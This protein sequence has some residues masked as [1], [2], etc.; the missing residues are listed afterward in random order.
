[1]AHISTSIDIIDLTAE[2]DEF[3]RAEYMRGSSTRV[4]AAA[5]LLTSQFRAQERSSQPSRFRVKDVDIVDLSERTPSPKISSK[6]FKSPGEPSSQRSTDGTVP[7]SLQRNSLLASPTRPA[8][9]SGLGESL[10]SSEDSKNEQKILGKEW[11]NTS[12]ESHVSEIPPAMRGLA[13]HSLSERTGRADTKAIRAAPLPQSNRFV[14]FAP[15]EKGAA[16]RDGSQSIPIFRPPPSVDRR[17]TFV[18][19][20]PLTEKR[21]KKQ[22]KDSKHSSMTPVI[23][24]QRDH[25]AQRRNSFP[26]VGTPTRKRKLS[27]ISRDENHRSQSALEIRSSR[28]SRPEDSVLGGLPRLAETEQISKRTPQL[29]AQT[30]AHAVE[31][32]DEGRHGDV[33]AGDRNPT[34]RQDQSLTLIEHQ[35]IAK[36][37]NAVIF[38]A[39][40]AFKKRYEN[41]IF[42]ED[43]YQ[44]GRT[45]STRSAEQK[46]WRSG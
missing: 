45:V 23:P 36:I 41:E 32:A 29:P 2:D 34:T 24:R 42:E 11:A 7:L 20:S 15:R 17:K 6:S 22:A 25:H 46:P 10:S 40:K 39:I 37:Y 12:T 27:D 16:L 3:E 8:F 13:E 33:G 1:M 38:P 21:M 43:L 4:D 30:I 26:L 18:F 5:S 28:R 31:R 19:R 35:K 9:D 44:I 14:L